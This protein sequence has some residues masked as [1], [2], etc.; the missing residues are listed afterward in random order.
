MEQSLLTLIAF[1]TLV[2]ISYL[3]YLLSLRVRI[4]SVLL[5]IA[6]GITIRIIDNTLHFGL[7]QL[8][9]DTQLPLLGTIGIIMIVLEAAIDLRIQKEKAILLLRAL[10]ASLLIFLLSAA[11]I[12]LIF[13]YFHHPISVQ[14]A[15]V[16]AIPLSVVSSAIII[17]SV[18]KL[19]E[20]KREFLIYESTF[21]D[22]IGIMV[23][24]YATI[25]AEQ[26]TISNL[27]KNISFNI[28]ITILLSI[29]LSYLLVLL[30]HNIKTKLKMFLIIAI[31]TLIYGI[32]KI[33]H[34]SALL[35]ILIF[36]LVLN[37]TYIFFPG[38]LS[39]L[40]NH[41]EALFIVRDFQ[42]LTTETA[43]LIRT[44]FF[45]LFGFSLHIESVIN[46]EVVIIGTAILFI[47]Y[48]TRFLNLLFISTK[49]VF[50]ELLLAP[51]GLVTILL[52]YAIPSNLIIQNFTPGIYFYVIIMS[53]LL[54]MFALWFSKKEK[55]ESY[56]EVEIGASP[57]SPL[58][59][60]ASTPQNPSQKE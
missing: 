47:L 9:L 58:F 40:I 32:G 22:I 1:S 28:L 14:Q 41:K 43:F 51:R 6:L 20:N 46:W 35:L 33:L 44:F 3:F 45:V 56:R 27:A 19:K 39:K 42:I 11:G 17:P 60:S 2:I 38:R 48:L 49:N 50:P 16:Y 52:Y 57:Y 53:N 18:E 26:I 21:S 29:I 25:P 5:L 54:M 10:I 31:L 59:D 4:P 13:L 37:N 36:G 55:V 15:I 24:N 30:F 12:T 8:K 7:N 34:I 23:F